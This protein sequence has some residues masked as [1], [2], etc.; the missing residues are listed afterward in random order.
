MANYEGLLKQ[1]TAY[2]YRQHLTETQMIIRVMA[3]QEKALDQLRSISEQLYI[4]AIQMDLNLLPF[5]VSGPTQT[6][7]LANYE[8]PDG[9]Y[10]DVSPK[11][12]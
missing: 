11:W 5:E 10:V 2:K 6:P 12:N 1:W 3:S 7:P 4:E 8:A 9:D